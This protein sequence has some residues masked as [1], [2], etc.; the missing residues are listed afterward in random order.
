M[1]NNIRCNWAWGPSRP[2]TAGQQRTQGPTD[3]CVTYTC[4]GP[5]RAR[6]LLCLQD[7]HILNH[8]SSELHSQSARVRVATQVHHKIFH[9]KALME[10]EKKEK[11]NHK[12][13]GRWHRIL[14]LIYMERKQEQAFKTCLHEGSSNEFQ[15]PRNNCNNRDL[16]NFSDNIPF[17]VAIQMQEQKVK[18]ITM[19]C[20]NQRLF[21]WARMSRNWETLK[22]TQQ[23]NLCSS[24][25]SG[26]RWHIVEYCG[27]YTL[28]IGALVIQW[29][30]L[31]NDK[32]PTSILLTRLILMVW[33]VPQDKSLQWHSNANFWKKTIYVH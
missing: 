12:R 22:L 8:L 17:D 2:L 27:E 6:G 13:F 30:F 31:L 5:P 23:A 7:A 18:Q 11:K 4:D 3:S 19:V 1:K 15:I 33:D 9:M 28:R 24:E 20:S 26:Q 14:S 25:P 10:G 21:Q 29:Q 16:N 32:A